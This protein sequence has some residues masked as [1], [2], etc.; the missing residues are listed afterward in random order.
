MVSSGVP[1]STSR[2]IS[3]ASFQNGT[4]AD[5]PEMTVS[6]P[7]NVLWDR[8]TRQVKVIFNVRLF[9]LAVIVMAGQSRKPGLPH[10]GASVNIMPRVS[11][12]LPT[13]QVNVEVWLEDSPLEVTTKGMASSA[14]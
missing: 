11:L 8:L 10:V 2:T 14:H 7:S 3:S 4:C 1:G 12:Q 6:V 5:R 9:H 13:I